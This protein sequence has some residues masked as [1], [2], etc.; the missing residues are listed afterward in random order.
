[1]ITAMQAFDEG[2][3]VLDGGLAT[4]LEARGH[5]ISGALWSARLLRSAPEAI[6]Q[7][8]YDYYAAGACVAITASYQ[9]SYEG[10]AA[11]GIG[12]D[13]TTSL[14]RLSVEL[15]CRARER[16]QRD[17]PDERRRLYV[18]ASVGPYG[19]ISHDGAEYRG[20]YGLTVDALVAFHARR[21]A[22]LAAAGADLLACET[23][24]VLDE[25][26]ACVRLLEQH[27]GT[28][29][30][31][32]FTSPDG[33]HTSHGEPLVE[34][35]QLADGTA[36]VVAVGV[37]CVRPEVVG[38]AIRSLKAGTGKPVVVYPNSGERWAAGEERWH[39]SP[40]GSGLAALAPQWI[41][42]GAR[43]VGGCCRV[44][45]EQIAGLTQ[46]L[47]GRRWNIREARAADRDGIRALL[48]A[49]G[50]PVS[51]LESSAP[52]FVVA[53]AGGR[54]VAA[55]GLEIHGSTGLLR[56]VVVER[57]S[58]KGGAGRA[59]VAAIEEIARAQGVNA[60]VLLTETARDFFAR[61]G[62]ESV[63][64]ED[65]AEDVRRS[66]EFRSICPQ[67]AH[68]MSKRTGIDDNA[69]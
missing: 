51:D 15:A 20:D 23:I 40:D 67:S 65:V 36:N 42:A 13:E 11:L 48:A 57:G 5:D 10:F 41:A 52:R 68:C 24:P 66:A 1:M 49:S 12:E 54:M 62:Y 35:A 8:H 58:R 9:A 3:L 25:A 26:R 16:Y 44:G 27:R 18:A 60:I 14:L 46:A 43:L 33:V 22:V 61:L 29:A 59:V 50:L 47:S 38:T 45:P 6:E 55:A 31:L 69:R 53:V 64:R 2:S 21:F 30:W 7:L 19:A 39:G 28:L 4:E 17:H 34:C 32:S 63:M 56:S 37:N